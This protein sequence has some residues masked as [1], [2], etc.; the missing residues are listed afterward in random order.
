M[1]L[2]RAH[3]DFKRSEKRD[4]AQDVC[5]IV[6]GPPDRNGTAA[7]AGDLCGARIPHAIGW[8]LGVRDISR[9]ITHIIRCTGL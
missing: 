1:N 3:D 4:T 2:V 6:V 7:A 5:A 9:D 8:R